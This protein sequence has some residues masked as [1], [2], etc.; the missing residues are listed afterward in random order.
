M[1]LTG[2]KHVIKTDP[3]QA[4]VG[5]EKIVDKRFWKLL[6]PW[7]VLAGMILMTAAGADQN[8]NMGENLMSSSYHVFP[9]SP[10]IPT[11]SDIDTPLST[12]WESYTPPG[13]TDLTPYESLSTP[14]ARGTVSA[15]AKQSSSGGSTG[16]R[17]TNIEF[18][19]MV[20][21]SGNIQKFMFSASAVL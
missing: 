3:E 2:V 14:S 8:Q 10:D 20:T 5:G 19:Q 1:C 12:E 11:T 7:I 17:V 4:D 9:V 6:L 15:W 18:N 21:A 13:T 16:G